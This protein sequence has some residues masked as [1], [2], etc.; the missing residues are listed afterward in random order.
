VTRASIEDRM[1]IED[2]FIRYTTAMDSGDVEGV[3]GCFTEDGRLDSPI[4]G[5][6]QG[7]EQL[8]AF[9]EQIAR[10]IQLRGAR[11][12]HVVTNFRFDVEGDRARAQCYLLDFVTIGGETTLLSPGEYDCEVVKRDER[13]L[14]ASR[15]VRMDRPFAIP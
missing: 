8:R 10:S 5:R 4:I 14:F 13:W 11:F 15:I 1:A 9:A 3:V 12:R 7:V 2:L 6:R